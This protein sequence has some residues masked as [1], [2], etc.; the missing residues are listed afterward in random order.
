[1]DQEELY[2]TI[3][4]RKSIRTYDPSVLDSASLE[5]ISAFAASV[6]PLLP[7]IETHMRIV[8]GEAVRGMFRV[9][10]PHFLV[11]FSN[12]KPGYLAN[13]GFMLQQMDLFLSASGLGSC[14]QG[15]PHLTRKAMVSSEPDPIIILAFGK[16][17]EPVHRVDRTEFKRREL[18][19]ITNL[20]GMAELMEPVRLAPSA[21]NNQPWYFSG[22]D[23]TID[24]YSHRSIVTPHMN[25][26]SAGIALCHLWLAAEHANRGVEFAIRESHGGMAPPGYAYV[27]SAMVT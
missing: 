22:S 5:R 14:W 26:I 7:G 12:A 25:Q 18:S 15:G 20:K 6:R 13:A 19:E 17:S 10:A 2:A 21:M 3:F 27:A 4:K 8:D 1:M 24:A 9:E 16:P 23:G 11:I